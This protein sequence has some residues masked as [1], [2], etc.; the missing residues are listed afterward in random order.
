MPIDYSTF[1]TASRRQK[2][3]SGIEKQASARGASPARPDGR[4][5]EGAKALTQETACRRPVSVEHR[6][7]IQNNIAGMSRRFDTVELITA[8][9]RIF[10]K[11]SFR[12]FL[13]IP[14]QNSNVLFTE[15]VHPGL[16]LARAVFI[17]SDQHVCNSFGP[18]SSLMRDEN[19]AT[20]IEYGL[21]AALIS[22]VIISTITATGISLSVTF[23]TIA[24]AL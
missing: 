1:V 4:S 7:V 5:A 10:S 3:R 20:A 22:V 13:Q 14:P 11:I 6:R 24:T 12:I 18:L 2:A 19:G 17:G 23:S 15:I 16:S 21:I 8:P 9:V